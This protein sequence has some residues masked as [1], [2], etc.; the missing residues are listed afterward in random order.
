VAGSARAVWW[1][2]LR[3]HEWRASISNR[4]RGS[5][6]PFCAGKRA[7]ADHCLAAAYPEIANE[8]HPTRNGELTPT[9]VTP[10]AAR[11]VWWRCPGGHEW[12]ARVSA[13]VRRHS[14]CPTCA[15]TTRGRKPS[16]AAGAGSRRATRHLREEHRRIEQTLTLLMVDARVDR[17]TL[18]RVVADVDAHLAA[19]EALLYPVIERAWNRP[20]AEQREVHGHLRFLLSMLTQPRTDP[21]LHARQLRDLDS[22]FREHARLTEQVALPWIEGALS[23][24]SLEALGERMQT[25]RA[26]LLAR[27]RG[28]A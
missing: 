10:R 6:C 5:G 27:A 12:Q 14:P 18:R 23:A 24:G 21:A 2:C 11:R 17:E 3:A 9:S 20:L 25:L 15:G 7:S 22:L 16:G 13:R 8:W 1:R 19:E 28:G 4:V 26:S